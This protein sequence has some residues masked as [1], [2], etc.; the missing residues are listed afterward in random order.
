MSLSLQIRRLRPWVGYGA[1]SHSSSNP[2]VVI[3][4]LASLR[5]GLGLGSGFPTSA[6]EVGRQGLQPRRNYD[7]SL[8]SPV[9]FSPRRR[10]PVSASSSPSLSSADSSPSWP[11][12]SPLWRHPQP[13]LWGLLTFPDAYLALIF[14][15]VSA[16]D[17][18]VH[19]SPLP[20]PSDLLARR[21]GLALHRRRLDRHLRRRRKK[22][23]RNFLRTRSADAC[24]E[25]TVAHISR[26]LLECCWH[27]D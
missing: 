9:C 5:T 27:A 10:L 2:T 7:H 17:V 24:W 14:S 3:A 22:M 6:F 11:S 26:T 19:Q 16:L 8:H 12:V 20:M 23:Y 4:I 15:A 13:A 18:I 25:Q 21:M 1:V